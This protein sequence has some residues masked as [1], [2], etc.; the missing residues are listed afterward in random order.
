[1]SLS[2]RI[3]IRARLYAATVFSLLLLAIVGALG[4][5]ALESSRATVH[6]LFA[7]QVQTLTAMTELR[8]SLG[9]LRRLEKDIVINF[10]NADAV[11]TL[12]QVWDRQRADLQDGL[13]R[14]RARADQ[15]AQFGA[16]IDR[17]LAEIGLYAAGVIPIF[18]QIER[19]QLDGAGAAAYAERFNGHMESADRVLAELTDQARQHMEQARAQ[20][21]TRAARMALV[22]ALAVAL[23]LLVQIPLTLLTVRSIARALRQASE[24]AERI[25]GGDLTQ[26][27]AATG[28]DEVGELIN[29]MGRMQ[30]ALHT[31]VGQVQQAAGGVGQAS[32]EI[33]AGNQDLSQRTEQTAASLQQTASSMEMLTSVVQQGA[34]SSR[35]A[36]RLAATAADVAGRGGAVVGQVT[37]AME[38]ISESSRRIGDITAVIDS[39]AFQT[40]ILALNAAVEAARAGE[41]GRGFAVVASEVRTLAQRSAQAAREIRELIQVSAEHVSGGARLAGQAGETMAQIVGSVR[42]VSQLVAEITESAAMQSD[43]LAQINQSVAHLDRMTQQNAALVEQSTAASA[44]LHGQARQLARAAGQFRLEGGRPHPRPIPSIAQ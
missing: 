14:V 24:L 25:A 16:A 19:A 18:E 11:G 40:N 43:N 37:Q 4:Y 33:A 31:L 21:D 30:Q 1:M 12:R 22:I 5:G 6:E 3:S 26:V 27:V 41:A 17:T 34:E 23:A 8:T 9:Q 29:A 13:G 39:I 32:S 35:H 36:S 10:N 7:R 38:K 44:A 15:D 42:Q 2:G 28:R 20:L